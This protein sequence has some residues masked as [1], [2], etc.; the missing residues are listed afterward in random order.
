MDNSFDL[1]YDQLDEL[2]ELTEL[3]DTESIEQ[4]GN[5]ESLHTDV[6]PSPLFQLKMDYSKEIFYGTHDSLLFE[7][8]DYVVAPTRYGEDIVQ[9]VGRVTHPIGSMPKDIVVITR[10]AVPVDLERLRGNAKKEMA[11]SKLF[12]E[13]VMLHKLEMKLVQ[14]HY[15]FEEP[16]VL[17]FFSADNRIDFRKLVKDLVA[18]LRI[19]IELRQIGV[20]D[21]ARITGGIGCC[22]RPFCCHAVT[23]KLK[24]VSIKMAKEQNLSLNSLKISGQCGRLLCC[25]A[26]EHGWYS[27]AKKS[28]PS[29]G[30][31]IYYDNTH[32]C[33]TDIN[34]LTGMAALAGDD[35]RVISMSTKRFLLQNGKWKIKN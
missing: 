8:G 4:V 29:T 32:F 28:L 27:E 23:D 12:K 35:G 26:Y 3:N 14:C 34:M 21:E 10:K 22:G 15:L 11:A 7:R 9:V 13:K 16:K 5:T 20:R 18:I 19:R 30:T 24:S 2:N 31:T 17:F 25:L 6:F 1:D 33:I